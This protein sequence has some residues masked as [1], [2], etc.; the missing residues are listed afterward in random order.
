MKRFWVL[1]V[2]LD[3]LLFTTLTFLLELFYVTEVYTLPIIVSIFV[4]NILITAFSLW[5]TDNLNKVNLI[6]YGLLG[7]FCL[8]PV[9]TIFIDLVLVFGPFLGIPLT[10]GLPTLIF[11]N[12][13]TFV[14]IFYFL[15]KL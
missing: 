9:G 3:V 11:D 1:A 13:V 14:W 12:V 2:F 4:I 8:I 10:V 6:V 7:I 5:I 15:S